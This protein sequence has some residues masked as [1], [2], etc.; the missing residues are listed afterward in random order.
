MPLEYRRKVGWI[1]ESAA[2]RDFGNLQPRVEQQALPH[3][4]LLVN[5]VLLKRVAGG[6]AVHTSQV[7]GR[8]FKVFCDHVDGCFVG[9][10]LAHQSLGFAHDFLIALTEELQYLLTKLLHESSGR[11]T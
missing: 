3:F 1:A 10:D 11:P 7:P 9:A 6:S 5:K 2:V 4:Q 8:E